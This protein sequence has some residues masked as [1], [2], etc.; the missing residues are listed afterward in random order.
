M[1]PRL[2]PEIMLRAYEAGLFPMAEDTDD[3]ELHW[4][5]PDPRAVLPLDRLHVP[6]SLRR[7]V[8]R[9]PYAIRVDTAFAQVLD[10]CGPSRP[11][12]ARSWLNREIAEAC[13]GLH[14]LGHAHSVEAW[15]GEELV[16][17]LYGV[18][19]GSAFFGESMFSSATDASKIALVHL[20]ARLVAGGF[21]LLDTQFVNDHLLQFGVVE[22][23][24]PDY[25]RRLAGAV[26]KPATF[27]PD[28]DEAELVDAFLKTAA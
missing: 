8:R 9:A 23:P 26:R 14:R 12:G 18:A 15:Q 10:R 3:P 25:K 1:L 16:G 27:L 2:T 7:S 22:I 11:D 6:R 24:R 17:G 28:G 5:D 20:A 4:F 19:L 21:T 13:L